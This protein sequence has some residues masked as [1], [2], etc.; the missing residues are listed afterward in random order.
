MK[1]STLRRV[2][3]PDYR[4]SDE[5]EICKRSFKKVPFG[6][7]FKTSWGSIDVCELCAED[8]YTGIMADVAGGI[9]FFEKRH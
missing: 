1:K 3:G 6:H 9:F 5:C 2:G 7:H 8:L 4:K